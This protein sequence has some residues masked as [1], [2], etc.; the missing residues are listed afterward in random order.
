MNDISDEA[1]FM[2]LLVLFGGIHVQSRAAIFATPTP[3]MKQAAV[4]FCRLEAQGYVKTFSM[5]ADIGL[6]TDCTH[7]DCT[8]QKLG[9]AIEPVSD[10][11]SSVATSLSTFS[12]PCA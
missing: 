9:C 11:Y 6:D 7:T 4:Q 1:R 8:M 2:H 5:L 10:I 3:F 12:V